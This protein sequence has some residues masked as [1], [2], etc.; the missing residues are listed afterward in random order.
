MTELDTV[1]DFTR[2][3]IK[4]ESVIRSDRLIV[5]PGEEELL[6]VYLQ[7]GDPDE[8]HD[9]VK[10]R[11]S[12]GPIQKRVS[13]IISLL[14]RFVPFLAKYCLLDESQNENQRFGIDAGMYREL[15]RRPEYREKKRADQISYVWDRLIEEFASNILAGTSVTPFGGTPDATGAE[16]ALRS[17]ALESRVERRMLGEALVTAMTRAEERKEDRFCRIMLPEPDSVDRGVAYVL[18]IMAY[19]THL[20]LKGGYEQYRKVRL[21]V[22][23]AYCLN[24]F[25]KNRLLKRVI[26]IAVDASA[27]I[28]GRQGSSEDILALE[29]PAWTEKLEQQAR[30]LTEQFDVMQSARLEPSEISVQEYP[31]PRQ[32]TS[33]KVLSRRQRRADEKARRKAL[34]KGR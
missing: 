32:D 1:S 28:T 26:G 18:L 24:V 33:K 21:N 15:T 5:A 19:P 29:I 3:L 12:L 22:L 34:W 9:F 10:P 13:R 30:D 7:S 16:K 14:A 25:S 27:K 20:N 17:M 8:G 2:Y 4:R 6:A 11:R 23:H 31:A